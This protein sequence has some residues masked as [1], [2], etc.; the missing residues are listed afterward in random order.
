MIRQ[1]VST[2]AE[3][4]ARIY[5]HYVR[6]T[7]V[8]F[9]EQPVSAEEMAKRLADTAVA[10]LPWLVLEQDGAI[11]GYALASKWKSRSAY[12]FA[13]ET[14]IYLAPH[15]V[16]KGAGSRLYQ[17]LVNDVRSR[18]FHTAIGGIAL[19]NPGSVAL[20]EKLGFRQV[21]HFSE[22]GFKLNRWIDVAYWQ[23]PL[24]QASDRSQSP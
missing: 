19:P 22:V 24:T 23:L 14:T 2:D 5:N 4:I 10:S 6:E 18:G 8:T 20:H 11:L 15:C 9:E 21:A 13:V 12:R 17:S 3:A 1:A 7:I 16:G